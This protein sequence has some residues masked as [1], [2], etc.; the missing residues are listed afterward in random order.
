M[1][2]DLELKLEMEPVFGMMFYPLHQQ[3]MWGRLLLQPSLTLPWSMGG[4][5]LRGRGPYL[6][7][8]N[9]CPT[10]FGIGLLVMWSAW[11]MQS[12]ASI[13]VHLFLRLIDQVCFPCWRLQ[14]TSS[15]E[16][17]CHTCRVVAHSS[18]GVV[19]YAMD[20]RAKIWNILIPFV[21]IFFW[22]GLCHY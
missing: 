6:S 21:V 20:K 7:Q 2:L 17:T 12:L 22:W 11:W 5:S 15:I 19:F 16:L 3:T 9:K 18:F 13:W 14:Q 8:R 4:R 1:D 10:T